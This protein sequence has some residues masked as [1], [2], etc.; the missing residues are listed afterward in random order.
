VWDWRNDN[1]IGRILII[2]EN[3]KINLGIYIAY[4][5]FLSDSKFDETGIRTM[6]F[7]SQFPWSQQRKKLSTKGVD[8]WAMAV[9]KSHDCN[10]ASSTLANC[11][12][13]RQP[14]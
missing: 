11:T 14:T 4:F 7:S 13:D 12:E 8:N 6:R 5:G 3:F 1:G 2:R 10:V 9:D